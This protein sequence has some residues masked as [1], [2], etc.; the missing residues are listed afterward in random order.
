MLLRM[1]LRTIPELEEQTDNILTVR[2]QTPNKQNQNH[3]KNPTPK[4]KTSQTTQ[5][6][7]EQGKLLH[8]KAKGIHLKRD[9][10]GRILKKKEVILNLH[11]VKQ[12]NV[13]Y[14]P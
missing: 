6:K 10:L 5:P 7:T 4:L 12:R 13:S 8:E 14:L 9:V 11:F 3:T 2:A 1:K